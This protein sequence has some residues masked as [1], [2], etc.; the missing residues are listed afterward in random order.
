MA[1]DSHAKAFKAQQDGLFDS[2]FYVILG[3]IVPV[4]TTILDKEG[5]SK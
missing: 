4:K 3:E 1:V 5:K 2:N